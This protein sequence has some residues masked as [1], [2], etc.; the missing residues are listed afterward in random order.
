MKAR[1]VAAVLFA[2]L[3]WNCAWSSEQDD[4]WRLRNKSWI[5]PI[6]QDV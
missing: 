3:G 5:Y 6:L 4:S 1:L 2:L